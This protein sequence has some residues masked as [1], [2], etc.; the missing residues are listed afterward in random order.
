M[1]VGCVVVVVGFVLFRGGGAVVQTLQQ[2]I[3]RK[4]QALEITTAVNELN[5]TESVAGKTAIMTNSALE[6]PGR[7]NKSKR[8][9]RPSRLQWR[10]SRA[11]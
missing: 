3:K 10:G 1:F 6:N 8:R 2:D 9:V 7:P 5:S 11:Q 4:S